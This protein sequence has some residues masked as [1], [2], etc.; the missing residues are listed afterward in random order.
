MQRAWGRKEHEN[1]RNSKTTIRLE[2]LWHGEKQ[3]EQRHGLVKVGL[4]DNKEKYG[5]GFFPS[6]V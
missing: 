3:R 5:S 4:T 2:K 1:V 6:F